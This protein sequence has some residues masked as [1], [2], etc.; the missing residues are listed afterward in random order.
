MMSP[1]MG[2]K[3]GKFTASWKPICVASF[4]SNKKK[5]KNSCLAKLNMFYRTN[6]IT[7]SGSNA[8]YSAVSAQTLS[9]TLHVS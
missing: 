8:W 4:E 1:A 5:A 2:S 7:T 3:I 6:S 9:L